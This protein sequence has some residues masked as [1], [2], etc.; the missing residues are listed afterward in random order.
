MTWKGRWSRRKKCKIAVSFF[1]I[2]SM[3]IKEPPTSQHKDKD[4]N[5]VFESR[6]CLVAARDKGNK[7]RTER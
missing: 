5:E 3:I 4:K 2:I 7:K 1:A 6:Q